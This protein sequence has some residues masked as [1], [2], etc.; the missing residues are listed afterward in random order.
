M[1]LEDMAVKSMAIDY[2]N[3]LRARG[4]SLKTRKKEDFYGTQQTYLP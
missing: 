3:R 2:E 1:W 4:L